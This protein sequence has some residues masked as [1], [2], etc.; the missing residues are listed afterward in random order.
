[1]SQHIRY[2]YTDFIV[3]K[4]GLSEPVQMRRGTRAFAAQTRKVKMLIKTLTMI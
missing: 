4:K 3:D 1:M 2:T